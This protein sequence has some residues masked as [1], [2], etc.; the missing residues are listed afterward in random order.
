MLLFAEHFDGYVDSATYRLAT[1]VGTNTNY[2]A[3][4][5]RWGGGVIGCGVNS[6]GDTRLLKA[7]PGSN[8]IRIAFH[9]KCARQ[10]DANSNRDIIR[11]SNAAGTRFWRMIATNSSANTSRFVCSKFDDVSPPA[12]L[13]T[14]TK[15][16]WNDGEWHHIEIELSAHISTG[17]FKIKMDGVELTDFTVA[18]GDTSDAV[19]G[20]VTA[21]DRIMF[22]G[23]CTNATGT[24]STLLIDDLIV[25]DDTGTGFT[26]ALPAEHRLRTLE[27]TA[28]GSINQWTP[29]AG[30]AFA[31][32]DEAALDGDTTYISE[33][34]AGQIDYFTRASLGYTPDAIEAVIVESIGKMDTGTHDWR[35]KLLSGATTVNGAALVATTDYVKN[36]TTVDYDPDTSAQWVQADL[37]AAEFGV[38]FVS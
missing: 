12:T 29:L 20:D 10:T 30:N 33:T 32:V 34:V 16:P 26:G 24:S 11:L 7:S 6:D 18:S 4:T 37:E 17:S 3:S 36:W 8:M 28:D 21:F 38:E 31:A 19:S 35:N 22:A 15:D 2:G 25:W 13:V 9:L 1:G 27:P 5:G 14:G 23:S